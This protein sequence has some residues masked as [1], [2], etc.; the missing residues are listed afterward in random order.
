MLVNLLEGIA[1]AFAMDL[2]HGCAEP[3][4]VDDHCHVNGMCVCPAPCGFYFFAAVAFYR[5]HVQQHVQF[6]C[7]LF[8]ACV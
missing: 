3:I 4:Y 5:N 6:V 2:D 1:C 8:R 7:N